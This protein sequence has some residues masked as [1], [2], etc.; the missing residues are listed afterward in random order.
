MS[1]SQ[2]AERLYAYAFLC[3]SGDNGDPDSQEMEARC[4]GMLTELQAAAAF[5]N[6]EIL[7][8]EPERLAQFMESPRLTPYRHMIDDICRCLLYTSRCV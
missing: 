2:R 3:K 1:A 6:P 4:I 7:A 8:I 5:V